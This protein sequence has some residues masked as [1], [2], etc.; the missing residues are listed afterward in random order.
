MKTSRAYQPLFTIGRRQDDVG[1]GSEVRRP[2]L[3]YAQ[4]GPPP[5]GLMSVVQQDGLATGAA[6]GLDVVQRVADEPGVFQPHMV[7][8]RGLEQHPRHRLAAQATQ[9][10]AA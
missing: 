5:R 6:T 8:A 10:V 9:G 4:L 7:L 1:G 3:S 2:R